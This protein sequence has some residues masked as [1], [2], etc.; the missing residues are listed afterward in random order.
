MGRDPVLIS[1]VTAIPGPRLTGP[2]SVCIWVLSSD[3][4]AA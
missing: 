1:T 4:R 2:V 3:T